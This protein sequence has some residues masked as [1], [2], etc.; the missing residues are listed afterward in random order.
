MHNEL[1]AGISPAETL[2]GILER[3]R[4]ACGYSRAYVAGVVDVQPGTIYRY[5]RDRMEPSRAV[6]RDLVELYSID[7][8]SALS[9]QN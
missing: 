6:L 7:P 3:A 5:E 4:L 1:P 9:A 8:A 2:G